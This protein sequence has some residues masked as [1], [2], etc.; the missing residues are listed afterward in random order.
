VPDLLHLPP[1]CRFADR[2]SRRQA[3][4]DEALPE[5]D[6]GEDSRSRVACY[7]PY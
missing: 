3:R 6:G 1:G 7:F 5:L 4:C 2:C